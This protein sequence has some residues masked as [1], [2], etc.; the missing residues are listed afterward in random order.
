MC[1]KD[2]LKSNEHQLHLIFKLYISAFIMSY[3]N[4]KQE[5]LVKV[6]FEIQ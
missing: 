3:T 5:D 6:V 4:P 1:F 2:H